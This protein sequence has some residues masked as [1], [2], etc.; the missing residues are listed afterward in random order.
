[1]PQASFPWMG[2]RVLTEEKNATLTSGQGDILAKTVGRLDGGGYFYSNQRPKGEWKFTK[3]FNR[4]TLLWDKDNF[5]PGDSVDQSMHVHYCEESYDYGSPRRLFIGYSAYTLEPVL[6][7]INLE[8][9]YISEDMTDDHQTGLQFEATTEGFLK[10]DEVI[11][12][13]SLT[14]PGNI[15]ALKL[16][17][18]RK[19]WGRAFHGGDLTV[20]VAKDLAYQSA[21]SLYH[22]RAPVTLARI[23][24]ATTAQV[25]NFKK[26]DLKRCVIPDQPYGPENLHLQDVLPRDGSIWFERPQCFVYKAPYMS[27]MRYSKRLY[28]DLSMFAKAH[29]HDKF[30]ATAMLFAVQ[31]W[32]DIEEHSNNML[33]QDIA[34][35]LPSVSLAV[36]IVYFEH[37]LKIH[38]HLQCLSFIHPFR[39]IHLLYWND[40]LQPFNSKEAFYIKENAIDSLRVQQY[41]RDAKA[42]GSR[43]PVTERAD[44]YPFMISGSRMVCPQD[45]PFKF[46]LYEARQAMVGMPDLRV[47]GSPSYLPTDSE[48]IEIGLPEP[49]ARITFL[50]DTPDELAYTK[51]FDATEAGFTLLFG[52]SLKSG[53]IW[54]HEFQSYTPLT[55]LPI[56]AYVYPNMIDAWSRLL[57]RRMA[58]LEELGVLGK[59]RVRTGDDGLPGY[60]GMPLENDSRYLDEAYAGKMVKLALEDPRNRPD[61]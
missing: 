33:E 21:R 18:L 29:S 46:R 59:V 61:S 7:S 22:R 5:C 36:F 20:E 11:L 28:H 52:D 49:I 51:V 37:W 55:D 50:R 39:L 56:E 40:I 4:G 35:P 58:W 1:M 48:I 27:N 43:I 44:L 45:I 12:H 19:D 9:F 47:L 38:E 32:C 42:I 3:V 34:E 31:L 41:V 14:V 10:G 60:H 2:A 26:S 13:H 17:L 25:P 24:P 16:L 57:D 53:T 8:T 30:N 54:T 15:R 6:A 23:Q